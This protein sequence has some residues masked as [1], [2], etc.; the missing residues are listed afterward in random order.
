MDTTTGTWEAFRQL[1]PKAQ[2]ELALA[3]MRDIVAEA[4]ADYV[5]VKPD[6][7]HCA[8]VAPGADGQPSA[9]CLIARVL[10][11]LG[12]PLAE[13]AKWDMGGESALGYGIHFG[14]SAHVV[15]ESLGLS[16]LT[17]EVLNAGQSAQDE[18]RVWGDALAEAEAT[19]ARETD[20]TYV[21]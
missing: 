1:A 4:G 17:G 6:G 8:Y 11:R 2:A 3:T 14:T 13:L 7:Y 10:T 19:C 15:A 20:V 12:L 21:P 9:S 18:G 5:Y 16:E